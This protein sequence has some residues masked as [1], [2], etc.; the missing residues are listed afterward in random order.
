[1]NSLTSCMCN[2][3]SSLLIKSLFESMTVAHPTVAH[4]DSCSLT[5][6]HPTIAHPPVAHRDICSLRQLL[7]ITV[8][9]FDICSPRQL[10]TL[11]VAH[12]TFAHH[13]SCSPDSCS[14]D[15]CSPT[16]AHRDSCSLTISC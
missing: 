15:S 10:L 12:P 14:P 1:M 6:T 3:A 8:A 7:T 16:V 4:H 13:D 11:T 2:G 9:H 5:I